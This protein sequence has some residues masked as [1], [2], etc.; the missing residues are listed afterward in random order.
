MTTTSLPGT[1]RSPRTLL[2]AVLAVP[3]TMVC[4]TYSLAALA[5]AALN[6]TADPNQGWLS[7][8]L[9]VQVVLVITAIM[10]FIV[11]LTRVGQHRIVTILSWLVIAISVATITASAGLSS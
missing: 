8:G 6:G 3:V 7:A 10:L 2:P 11:A 5:S 9:Y 4:G 1:R